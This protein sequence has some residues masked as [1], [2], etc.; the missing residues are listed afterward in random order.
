MTPSSLLVALRAHCAGRAAPAAGEGTRLMFLACPESIASAALLAA[1]PAAY[2]LQTLAQPPQHLDTTWRDT[3]ELGVLASGVRHI[4]VCGHQGCRGDGGVATPEASQAL[5]VARCRA[6]QA[7]EQVGPMLRS[8]GAKMEALWFEEAT[9]DVYACD[10]EGRP[11]RRLGDA[12]LAA[13]F[14]RFEEL[15]A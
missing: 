9:Q 10:L 7:D 5:L 1:F 2:V 12:E 4:V 3:F 13:T 15:S 8:A 6:I 11:A 14:T